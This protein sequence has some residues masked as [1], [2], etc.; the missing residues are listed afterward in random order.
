M[1]Y[2]VDHHKAKLLDKVI[3]IFKEKLSAEQAEL[4]AN[5]VTQFFST[6]A[7]E[8]LQERNI[9]DLCGSIL[10]FWG[11]LETRKPNERKVHVYN[12]HFEQHGWQSTHT[13]VE[14]IQSD[15][16]FLVDSV[17]MAINRRG[18]TVHL[19]IHAGSIK[20]RRD[21][22]HKVIEV[23]PQ[24]SSAK[25]NVHEEAPIYLEIDRQTDPNILDEIKRDLEH[26]LQDVN[27]AVKDW[28]AMRERMQEAIDDIAS[29]KHLRV[30]QIEI[31]E[32]LAFLRWL[33]EG[34]FTF[35]GCRDY[36]LV[37][38]QLSDGSAGQALKLE[39]GSGLG[40]LRDD[41]KSKSL[42]LLAD[43][44][45]DIQKLMLSSQILVIA[46]TN[47]LSTVH[48][49][50]YTDFIRIGKF[51]AKGKLIGE[52]WIIGLFTAAAYHSSP[53]YI[54]LL[55]RKVEYVIKHSNINPRSHA[56]KALMN[57][58]ETL[59]RD[60]LFQ[61]TED[62]LLE[63]A[64]G[65]LQMQERRRIRLFHRRDIYGRFISCLVYVPRERFNTELRIALQNILFDAFQAEE[66]S[67]TT[68]FSDSVLAR[69]HFIIRLDPKKTLQYDIK[70]IETKL[71]EV[72]R[73]WQDELREALI[74][75][76]GE[77]K[78]NAHYHSYERAFTASY[79]EVFSPR[80][81]VYDIQ[82]LEKIRAGSIPLAMNFYRSPEQSKD[83]I[84]FKLYRME[85]TIPLS[86][87]LPIL[88][89]MGLR[90]ISEHPHQINLND[91]RC[92]WI[93]D[94]G[95]TY[96]KG[97]MVAIE[98]VKEIFQN[99]FINIWLR[100]AENDAFN[101]LALLIGLNWREIV[102]LRAYAKYMRQTGFTFSQNYL[103]E[104]LFNNPAITKD[105]VTLFKLRFDPEPEHNT[106]KMIEKIEARLLKEL[107]SVA[108]LDEDRILRRYLAV[109]KA[110]LRTNYFQRLDDGA[111]KSYLSF[112]F[113][114]EQIPD[115]PLPRPMFE[116][117]VYSPRFEGVHLRSGKVARGGI[118]WSDRRED[119]R[120]EI[121]GLMKAQKVKNAVIVPAG[122]KGGFVA[123]Q[124]PD[125]DREAILA[126]G[127]AC[128]QD[129]IRGLL[130][131]TDNLHGDEIVY[132]DNVTRYDG[133]DPYLVIA[134]DKGTASFSNIANDIAQEYGFWLGDAF[135]SGGSKGY[136]HK[137][138]G[139]TARGAWESVKRQF[140]ELGLNTQTTDFTV[141]G[142]GD[143]AGDVF[144]NGMLLSRH[145][146]LVGAFNHLHIFLDPNPDP[147]KSF[148]ERERLFNL[149]RSTWADYDPKLI[150]PGGGVFSRAAKSIKLTPEIKELL[151]LKQDFIVPN[152]LLRHML[153]ARVD[154]LWNGGIGT[155]VKGTAENNIDVGDRA[156]DAIRINGSELRCRVVGE[157]GNLGL[158]QLGRVEY[159]LNGGFIYTDFIDNSAG[160][161]CSDHEVNIKILLNAVV[162]DG[163]MTVKQRNKLLA[164][165][166][167]EVAA[168][169]LKNNYR[170]TQAISLAA[171]QAVS[172]IELHRRY[173]NDLEH[174]GKLDRSL[175]FLP[176]EKTLMERKLEGQGL[177][178][179][180]IAVLLAY[181]KTILKDEILSSNVP[182]DPFLS[183][184][185]VQ[186]F[187]LPLRVKF[188][189]Q[190]EKHSL[191]REIIAT[192]LS[193]KMINEMGF[194]FI[195]RL[196]DETG[197]PV[198]AIVR[199]YTI[200][201]AVFDLDNLWEDIEKLDNQVDAEL[202]TKMLFQI[203]R[204]VRRG[205]RW[206]LRNR[207]IRLDIKS[208]IE[209][210]SQGI[211]N[212]RNII[213]QI[214]VGDDSEM[215][216]QTM[217]KYTALG[218]SENIAVRLAGIPSLL[219]TLDIVEAA[220]ANNFS[221]AEVADVYFKL[222]EILELD[223]IRNQITE[224]SVEN[225]WDALSREALRD[226]IDWQQ[227]QLAVSILRYKTDISDINQCITDWMQTYDMLIGRWRYMLAELRASSTL[228]FTMFFVAIRELL[229]LTQTCF[230]HVDTGST[231]NCEQDNE[232]QNILSSAA[233]ANK[234]TKHSK[235][236]DHQTLV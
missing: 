100:Q 157:G 177:K 176:D 66:I 202:Q 211:N 56:G 50:V 62:E 227:R 110:T 185:L 135:A 13:I 38:T 208:T 121:L 53:Q 113:D 84:H 143:M 125:G 233:K 210:F 65:I 47:T 173:I 30:E 8:D 132:P 229:D 26:V 155:F 18:L 83:I 60:D 221:I 148:N 22:Q 188:R 99:A 117:F 200:A 130:D 137:K 46:K 11:L 154:L 150:S 192:Q 28:Q 98:T 119:F 5:F 193:N 182:E 226:D 108:N 27:A 73:S 105:L 89:N 40:V 80:S 112:K 232:G 201:R 203:I 55:R 160:V 36:T 93:N 87:I 58:I 195:Y 2:L 180:G 3:E 79:R 196:S 166:T 45:D 104:T 67:F 10:A 169:V 127:I 77:E 145:I 131:I 235:G 82:H 171:M 234:N 24:A 225:H 91:G 61:A 59:P 69:I 164:E 114:P 120:T 90:V 96:A 146:K 32:S 118:R 33:T 184:I 223:W 165:M 231:Q 35:L 44:P 116:I 216:Q 115:L 43:M 170:Q 124:L 4:L 39:T 214:L 52:R 101:K 204:L 48:R 71:I 205:T 64:V 153:K 92:A 54:P 183:N 109:I 218:V 163:D 217:I 94:F 102:M 136:D 175:E 20:F 107:D 111:Y 140:R 25:K 7:Y 85:E 86:D 181:S 236:D 23:L 9:N 76:L 88:E 41:S 123:K 128:Y 212:L 179:P 29:H 16:P 147:E 194:T 168:L 37:N 19:I 81:A 106:A 78:G 162:A 42:R 63:L 1:P 167:D 133:D 134:A 6:V 68:L 49:P 207:R 224:H 95:M 198:S 139:I 144:G 199:A 220:T 149:E 215:Y 190:M 31:E 12:P 206:F 156:N 34:Q 178:K 141:I 14:I 186:A 72:G 15:M 122:A 21:D 174:N 74:E 138:M 70:E 51:D 57:I 209:H 142:I 129:F 152:D 230:Q 126:E 158:T 75:T 219:S 213:T 222:S 187:P 172:N 228:N 159:A 151:D 97:E 161:D 197:A 17:C 191:R 103:E 189:A